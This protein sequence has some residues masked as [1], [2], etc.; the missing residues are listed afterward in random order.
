MINATLQR[1][2]YPHSLI[3]TYRYWHV[4]LR[5]GQITLGSLVLVCKE[6]IDS[7]SDIS[8]PAAAEKKIIIEHVETVLKH[9]LA[10]SKVNYL[11]LMMIDPLVHTHV[12]PR[13]EQ[14]IDYKGYTF[15]D[16]N[17]PMPPV[18]SDSL[19]IDAT[20]REGLLAEL[21]QEF[22]KL[23][24]TVSHVKKYS[25]MY[26]SGSF[27]IFHYGHLNILKRTKALCDH[28]VVGVS[29]DEVIFQ[30]KGRNPL[31]PFH[32]RIAVI[33]A[34]DIV[35]EVIPQTDKN[36]QKIVDEYYIDA[37]SVGD[38]W[39]GSYPTV[40]CEMEYFKYTP[41]VSSTLLK[42]KLNLSPKK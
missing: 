27:D 10:Y 23:S 15:S 3:K 22:S 33:E 11:T 24:S 5:P 8:V 2:D 4:L 1:F 21:K 9:K 14:D 42:E 28:L 34:L 20:L 18:M 30:S 25:R 26:S 32:E 36:K 31:I 37:I 35:D 41:N 17:W 39:K 29:T 7:C 12:I 40:T 38:D 19:D 13:Y 16:V 6:N